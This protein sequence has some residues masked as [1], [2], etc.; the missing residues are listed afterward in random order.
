MPSRREL[1]AAVGTASVAVAG[2]TALSGSDGNPVRLGRVEY[3]DGAVVARAVEEVEHADEW[4]LRADALVYERTEPDLFS[5]LTDH[6]VLSESD[7]HAWEHTGLDEVHDWTVGAVDSTLHNWGTNAEQTD[8]GQAQG[9]LRNHSASDV[10]RWE[11]RLTPP[12]ASLANYQFRTDIGR[13]RSID[14]GDR[15]AECRSTF[16]FGEPGLL[17]GDG[18]L[19]LTLELVYGETDE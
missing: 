12:S 17:G 5:L 16:H 2:C 19:E 7:T 11:I 3:P 9:R 4:M 1:L 13:E 6:R 15:L 10:G 18:R 14:G 8:E